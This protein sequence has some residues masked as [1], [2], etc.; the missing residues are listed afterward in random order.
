MSETDEVIERVVVELRRPVAES[1]GA[2]ARVMAAVRASAPDARASE[3]VAAVDLAT[4]RARRR[5][6]SGWGWLTRPRTVTISPAGGLA[7]AAGVAAI[8]ASVALLAGRDE[9]SLADARGQRAAGQ[10]AGATTFVSGRAAAA[11]G[12]VRMVQF[13]LVAPGAS[14]VSLVGDFNDW[15]PEAMPLRR[16]ARDGAWT[17]EVPLA[18]GRH[19]YAFVVDGRDWVPDPNAP[20]T[21]G[22]DF[23]APNSVIMVGDRSQ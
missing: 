10:S 16:S 7:I 9:A 5:G 21:P 14:R 2:R 12:D 11:V 3:S 23:G 19:I 4:V 18:A 6:G 22:D 17:A 13:V 15:N 8:V 1:A 20:L